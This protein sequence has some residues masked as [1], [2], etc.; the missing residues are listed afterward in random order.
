M[1]PS[2]N[3]LNFPDR[4][5]LEEEAAR[6]V[7]RHDNGPLTADERAQFDAWK[8][9]SPQNAEA[10]AR[11]SGHWK[12]LD[13]LAALADSPAEKPL[14]KRPAVWAGIGMAAAAAFA[15]FVGLTQFTSLPAAPTQI[16]SAHP[17]LDVYKTPVGGQ[18]KITL[19]DGTVV[20]L[21]TASR[22]ETRLSATERSVRLLEGEA[23]F[24]VAHDPSRPFRV[25]AGDGVTVAVGTAFSVRLKKDAVEVVVSEGKVSYARVADVPTP[26]PVAFVAAG[27]A[28]VFNE[29]VVIE[30][31][32]TAVVDRKLS[33]TEGRLVF[34]G[35]R[36]SSV[37]ADISRYTD[38]QFD[39]ATQD[40]ADMR[41]GGIF[42]VG[43]V[44]DMLDAIET[45]FGLQV[46]RIDDDVVRISGAPN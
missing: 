34:A 39:F 6:W 21:N 46:E 18:Q 28:A 4:S 5:P 26:E 31:V 16:A 13:L 40:L 27:E 11:L 10:F 36:L 23:Y 29:N 1:S 44:D 45:N 2:G 33:W 8:A 43:E 37:V 30:K 12:D 9:A 20:T 17:G 19:D 24:E 3:I 41:V 38:L 32:D 7:V 14:L 42:M 25:Y 22:I 15:V 35:D